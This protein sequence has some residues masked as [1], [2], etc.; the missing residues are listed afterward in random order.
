MATIFLIFLS[1]VF[2]SITLVF[3]RS[4]TKRLHLIHP[5]E[6]T[7]C[8]RHGLIDQP[9]Q[10]RLHHGAHFVVTLKCQRQGFHTFCTMLTDKFEQI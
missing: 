7:T 9:T 10:E 1:C 6:Q 5:R 8:G 2:E 4:S 3:M